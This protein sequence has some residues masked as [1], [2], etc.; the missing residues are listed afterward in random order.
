MLAEA[1]SIDGGT[2]LLI[3][4]V[5]VVMVVV[6]CGLVVL[7]CRLARQAG[8]GSQRALGGWV[9]V[10]ILE[11]APLVV[12]FTPLLLVG[13]AVLAVQ[14]TFYLRGKADRAS[15]DDP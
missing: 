4:L 10:G 7:G 6:W 1:V 13:V 8:Q 5:L 11:L 12:G 14:V 2:L 9:V 15:G 3:L